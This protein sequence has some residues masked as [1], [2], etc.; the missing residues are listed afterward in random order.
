MTF[1]NN[2]LCGG[3]AARLTRR[4]RDIR[5]KAAIPVSDIGESSPRIPFR[6]LKKLFP[7]RFLVFFVSVQLSM[8]IVLS[9][10]Q[11]GRP[12]ATIHGALDDPCA[13][14][15]ARDCL[16]SLMRSMSHE[17]YDQKLNAL[18]VED[19]RRRQALQMADRIKSVSRYIQ[20]LSGKDN[21]LE[22]DDDDKAVFS[23]LAARLGEQAEDIRRLAQAYRIRALNASLD[24][25]AETC[26][27]CHNRFHVH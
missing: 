15:A 10:C 5:L 21:Y 1:R 13:M 23:M 2:K 6:H 17:V 18:E 19:E 7:A 3:A 27:E 25:V 4:G 11:V 26:N 8:P 20:D 16:R 24:R 9:A 14:M 12:D 22:L